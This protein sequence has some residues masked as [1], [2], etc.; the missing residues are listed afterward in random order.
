MSLLALGRE[1]G[2]KPRGCG[3]FTTMNTGL[4][5]AFQLQAVGR[6]SSC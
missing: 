5:R 3:M 6:M 4:S 2:E 1:E